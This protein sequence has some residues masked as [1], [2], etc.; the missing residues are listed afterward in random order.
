VAGL[1]G[2]FMRGGDRA[3]PAILSRM[4]DAAPH[5]ATDGG[6]TFCDGPFG[7]IRQRTVLT[8]EDEF[9]RRPIVHRDPA[10]VMVFDGRL[11]NRAELASMLAVDTPRLREM[12]D[13]FLALHAWLRWG[14]ELPVHLL[15]DFALVVWDG[16]SRSVFC[17]ADPFG[18]RPLHYYLSD[19]V[20][21]FASELTQL[22]AHPL[23]PRSPDERGVAEFL[24][25]DPRTPGRTLYR[26]VHRL[27]HGRALSVSSSVARQ[28]RYW[29]P[30]TAVVRRRDAA[31]YADAF[32]ERFDCAVNARLRGRGGVAA[33][34]SGGL[35]SSSVV[36]TAAHLGY[37]DRLTAFSLAFDAPSEASERSYVED[38]LQRCAVQGVVLPPPP[39]DPA[40]VRGQ[41]IRRQYLPDFPHS[42]I[43]TPMRRAIASRGIRVAL[44]GS[45]GD[46][47]LSGSYFYYADLLKRGRIAAFLRRYHDVATAPEHGWASAELLRGALWPLLPARLR[48]VLRPLARR[49]SHLAVPDWIEPALARRAGLAAPHDRPISRAT[50]SLANATVAAG[51]D[52]GLMHLVHDLYELGSSE[53]CIYDRHPFLD[54]SLVE[55][56]LTLPDDQRWSRGTMK[57]VLRSAMAGRLPPSVRERSDHAKSDFS[58]LTRL[59][60]EGLGGRRFFERLSIESEGWV[61]PGALARRHDLMRRLHAARDLRY[62]DVGWELWSAAAIELWYR[63]VFDGKPPARRRL[64]IEGNTT[65]VTV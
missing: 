7:A 17:A 16:P 44:T 28:A 25:G 41:V 42:L 21:V 43:V 12:P 13:G 32:R 35:D 53:Q 56:L 49:L 33:H 65:P 47:G 23:V 4:A 3:E 62:R 45:G 14:E 39:F 52:G 24:C 30:R 46:L 48:R 10:A 15:G 31:E 40:E 5:R 6:W 61:R 2:V 18:I 29:T 26:D 9:E 54:R 34:L 59:A 37:R 22:L 11:D 60:L 19:T 63:G 50:V 36:A 64:W 1:A 51:Y 8:P 57:L 27:P 55:F 38:V 58:H 20:L